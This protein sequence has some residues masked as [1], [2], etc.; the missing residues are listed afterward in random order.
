MFSVNV[1]GSISNAFCY[2][3]TVLLYIATQFM[4]IAQFS[5]YK[6]Q[7]DTGTNFYM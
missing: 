1:I 5:C 2:H 6:T 3:V 7:G 4:N